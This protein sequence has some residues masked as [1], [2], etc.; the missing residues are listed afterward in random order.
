MLSSE[1]IRANF[2]DIEELSTGLLK[3]KDVVPAFAFVYYLALGKNKQADLLLVTEDFE[4]DDF[5]RTI[6]DAVRN[7]RVD[8]GQLSK[9]RLNIPNRYNFTHYVLVPPRFHS[10]FKGRLDEKRSRL[11]LCLP[12]HECEFSGDESPELFLHM[13]RYTVPTLDW[14]RSAAPKIMLRFDNPRTGSGTS[15]C[16]P[17]AVGYSTL[18]CEIQNLNGVA[19]GFI[20]ITSF[21]GEFAEILSPEKQQFTFR[22][23]SESNPRN[24]TLQEVKSAAHAFLSS[25]H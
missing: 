20:E 18:E 5:A 25:G 2:V 17:V 16:A 24:M 8:F 1:D 6:I 9:Q 11:V 21:R 15:D 23:E 14:Q 12:I 22:H 13:R 3:F 19:N 4:D 10:Y 7:P